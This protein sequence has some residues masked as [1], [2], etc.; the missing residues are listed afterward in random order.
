LAFTPDGRLL[1]SV[2]GSIWDVESGAQFGTNKPIPNNELLAT[3]WSIT[4]SPDGSV[5]ASGGD[6]FGGDDLDEGALWLWDSKSG[7]A[8]GSPL[9]G[10]IGQLGLGAL[11]FSPDGRLIASGGSDRTVRAWDAKS[12]E[13]IAPPFKGHKTV[14]NSVAFSPDGRVI[15]SGGADGVV[16][17][18]DMKIGAE[19]KPRLKGHERRVR[20]LAFLQYS[21]KSRRAK[22]SVNTS[23][24]LLVSGGEDGLRMWNLE[25][26]TGTKLVM[27]F[28]FPEALFYSR[29]L[30]L[31]GLDVNRVR[32]TATSGPN[33]ASPDGRVIA[34]AQDDGSVILFDAESGKPI[35]T[36][37]KGD[38]GEDWHSVVFRPDG[39]VMATAGYGLKLWDPKTGKAIGKA[40]GTGF[41]GQDMFITSLAFSPDGHVVASGGRDGSV[42]LWDGKSGKGIGTPLVGHVG[43]VNSLAFSPDGRVIASAGKDGTVRLWDAKGGPS[44]TTPFKSFEGSVSSVLFSP[45]GRMIVAGGEDGTVRFWAA[46]PREW[47]RLA[48]AR[49]VRHPLLLNPTGA[50]SDQELVAAG[51][52]VHQFCQ[53]E[54]RRASEARQQGPGRALSELVARARRLLG[55]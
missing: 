30:L 36:P 40:I 50:T 19:I 23:K 41:R 43:A 11:A 55:G 21:M 22:D 31:K 28:N 27:N 47:F 16:R 32:L 52:R 45:D 4:S 35:G 26:G 12:G 14:V 17:L 20:S 46:S 37:L 2:G 5:I 39:Q 13:A 49:M 18:W 42:R 9:K 10:H 29:L 51:K 38:R 54:S 24:F 34:V 53:S 1:A 3:L 44:I 7:R 6:A 15:A 25:T 33:A 8:I 48:C